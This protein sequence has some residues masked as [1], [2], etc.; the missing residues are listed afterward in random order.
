MF[1]HFKNQFCYDSETEISVLIPNLPFSQKVFKYLKETL[2][3][4]YLEPKI[5]S[6]DGSNSLQPHVSRTKRF[7]NK[8]CKMKPI[9]NEIDLKRFEREK[10]D[11]NLSEWNKFKS[12]QHSNGEINLKK[13]KFS[14][15]NLYNAYLD[16]IDE[17]DTSPHKLQPTK[18]KLAKD[19]IFSKQHKELLKS[20]VK[21][22]AP[23]FNSN[24]AFIQPV[25]SKPLISKLK[26]DLIKEF[27]LKPSLDKKFKFNSELSEKVE[28][29]LQNL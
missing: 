25:Y 21:Q 10:C 4:E 27:K 29:F 12:K 28:Q 5:G 16:V 23:L 2:H 9:L 22:T 17:K 8:Y 15:R 14:D 3:K 6:F 20:K 26:K 7:R 11:P 18:E 13:F 19:P 1:C 24:T